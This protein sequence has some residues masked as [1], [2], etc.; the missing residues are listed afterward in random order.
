[1]FSLRLLKKLLIQLLLGCKDIEMKKNFYDIVFDELDRQSRKHDLGVDWPEKF[2]NK[3]TNTE[4]IKH[5][6]DC[7][8]DAGIE[9][10]S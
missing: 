5:I 6:S 8:E 2:V 7:L 10:K 9:F 3:M 1:M 4:L